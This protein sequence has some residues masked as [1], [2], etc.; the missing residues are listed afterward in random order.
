MESYLQPDKGAVKANPIPTMSYLAAS[1]RANAGLALTPGVLHTTGV[2]LTHN[3]VDLI[4]TD[5]YD[6]EDLRSEVVHKVENVPENENENDQPED[7]EE[8]AEEHN[9]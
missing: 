1:A 4:D 6:D 3:V 2:E 5:D 9:R 8:Q 7:E